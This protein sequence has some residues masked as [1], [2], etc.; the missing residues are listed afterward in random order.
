MNYLFEFIYLTDIDD[1]ASSPCNN[2]GTCKDE[3]NGF[4]CSCAPGFTGV[5]CEHGKNAA[6]QVES[7]L[8][9]Y[10]REGGREG[11]KERERERKRKRERER[12]RERELEGEGEGEGEQNMK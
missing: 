6:K 5:T 9:E 7:E 3:V 2:S 10:L 11:E 12:E 1:C 8:T 4:N